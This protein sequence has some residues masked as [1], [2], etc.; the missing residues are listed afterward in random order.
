[1]NAMHF[2][3]RLVGKTKAGCLELFGLKGQQTPVSANPQSSRVVLV[4]HIGN[5]P[6]SFSRNTPPKVT[7]AKLKDPL[8][9]FSHPDAP[10]RMRPD[11]NV[12]PLAMGLSP[13]QL[14]DRPVA[15]TT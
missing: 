13:I 9:F 8:G 7:L 12:L 4:K 15:N 1:M 6:E 5:A 3:I 2:E 11:A 14:H 10:L